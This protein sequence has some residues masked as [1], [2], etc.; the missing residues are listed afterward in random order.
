MYAE[1]LCDCHIVTFDQ[2]FQIFQ[3]VFY[4]SIPANILLVP[5]Y[6]TIRMMKTVTMTQWPRPIV[7]WIMEK[8]AMGHECLIEWG[9]NH[10][11]N[12]NNGLEM[13]PGNT[14]LSTSRK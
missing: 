12:I 10:V 9:L 6:C 11:N 14:Q 7:T 3:F 5:G 13:E 2:T 4:C 8:I 1:Y